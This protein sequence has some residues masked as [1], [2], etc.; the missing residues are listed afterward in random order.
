[1]ALVRG[2][3]TPHRFALVFYFSTKKLLC[4]LWL[5]ILSTCT[6]DEY[7]QPGLLRII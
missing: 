1:M 4:M 5:L 7:P 6:S 2:Y 3:A